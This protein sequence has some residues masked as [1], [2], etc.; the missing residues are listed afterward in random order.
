M[1]KGSARTL[2][3]WIDKGYSEKEA[4]RMRLSRTPGTLE[5]FTIFKKLPLDEAVKQKNEYNK[6]R[7]VTLDNLVKRH[8]ETIGKK[9]WESYKQKQAYTNSYE[10]KKKKY[11]WTKEQFNHYNKSRGHIGT[12]NPNYGSSYYDRWVEKYGKEIADEM[13]KEVSLKKSK[14]NYDRE[15]K[16]LSYEARKKMSESAKRRIKNQSQ[17]ISYNKNAIPIIE[18]YGIDN[19]YTFQHAENG[20]EFLV[21][22]IFYY[23]DGYDKEH[24]VVIEYYEKHHFNSDG[25][26]SERDILR[27]ENI[28]KELDCMFVEIDYLGNIKVYENKKD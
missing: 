21:P 12:S 6:K 14:A 20:G 26:L 27:R 19:G 1:G 18:Q 5:Y 25:S 13:N 22:N 10:Y 24:N 4:E 7:A 8:G 17:F 15:Y 3:H 28:M 11:G 16:P 9:K 23:L 2:Q